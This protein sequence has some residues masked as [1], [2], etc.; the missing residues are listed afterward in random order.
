MHRFIRRSV[1]FAVIAVALLSGAAALASDARRHEITIGVAAVEPSTVQVA[2][3]ERVVFVNRSG[4][5]IH[6][7]FRGPK[8]EHHVVPVPGAIS[9]EFHRP[10]RHAYVV[11]FYAGS[12][13]AELHG[14][15]D[16][17]HGPALV[18]GPEC[19]GFTIEEI[20][21]ER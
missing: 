15:I 2:L 16:V 5:A 11:H 14:S 3:H 1:T 6:V 8:G 12:R 17:D 18:R 20:C 4:R 7:E 13:P 10:G 21:I 19:G 9:A